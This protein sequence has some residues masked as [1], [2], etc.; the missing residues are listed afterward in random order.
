MQIRNTVELFYAAH[1]LTKYNLSAL[2]IELDPN[3]L[4]GK[5]MTDILLEDQGRWQRMKEKFREIRVRYYKLKDKI[6]RELEEAGLRISQRSKKIKQS[7]KRK[8]Q[9]YLNDQ[10]DMYDDYD[11]IENA[12]NQTNHTIE[13]IDEYEYENLDDDEEDNEFEHMDDIAG[14]CDQVDWNVLDSNTTVYMLTTFLIDDRIVC[15]ISN[16]EQD[17]EYE[18]LCEYGLFADIYIT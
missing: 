6:V 18:H 10:V 9:K 8:K 12:I 17:L 1:I 7:I 13:E 14:I 11:Y 15:S 16:V 4:K 3:L 2:M 5:T